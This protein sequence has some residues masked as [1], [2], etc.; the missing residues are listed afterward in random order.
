[1]DGWND[2]RSTA[3]ASI[4]LSKKRAR[5]GVIDALGRHAPRGDQRLGTLRLLAEIDLS[6]SV[7]DEAAEALDEQLDLVI[8]RVGVHAQDATIRTDEDQAGR[9]VDEVHR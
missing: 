2:G 4:A 8:A 6:L 1:M 9:V 5:L 3:D 7:S